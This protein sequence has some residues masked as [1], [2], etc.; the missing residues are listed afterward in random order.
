MNKNL[1]LKFI[2]DNVRVTIRTRYNKYYLDFI[3]NGK[4]IKRSTGLVANETNLKEL[5]R[6][7]IPEI[8]K[9]LTGNTIIEYLKK[10][11]LFNEFSIKFFEIYKGSGVRE[12][13]Y[14]ANYSIYEKQIKP[15][16]LKYNIDEIKPLQ[17]EEWQNKLL[18]KYSTHT[19]IR[20]RSILNLIL[21]KAFEN[22]IIN[23]NPLSKVKYPSSINKKFKKLDEL[24]ETEIHPFNKDEILKILDNAKGNLYYFIYIMLCTGMRPGEIISLTWND[25]NFEKNELLLIKQ[26]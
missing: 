2:Y 1:I 19:V 11:I 18:D 22:D 26:Q 7:I 9:T 3:Y 24:E 15:Y 23:I 8:F 6:N 21:S 16:F 17:L 14:E 10:D 20:Y 12:H 25:I 4:R 5:K 13:I